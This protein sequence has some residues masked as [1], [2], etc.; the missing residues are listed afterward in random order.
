MSNFTDQQASYWQ[1]KEEQTRI[2]EE[3]WN[4]REKK[5]YAYSELKTL[6]NVRYGDNAWEVLDKL[7]ARFNR[8]VKNG[9]NK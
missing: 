6:A 2:E 7:E 9:N 3:A 1:K 5:A 8:E 4:D